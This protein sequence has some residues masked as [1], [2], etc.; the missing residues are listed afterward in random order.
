MKYQIPPEL[1]PYP[2]G[3]KPENYPK[4]SDDLLYVTEAGDRID[5]VLWARYPSYDFI[6]GV[7]EKGSTR[8]EKEI[9]FFA[10]R[11]QKNGQPKSQTMFVDII[12]CE[13]VIR[14]FTKI[15]EESKRNST[16]L[17]QKHG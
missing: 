3:G 12:E 1:E 14:G 7:P 13:E 11:Y 4:Q 2:E 6:F 10:W 9:G 15:L 8:H 17:W 16:H 5:V